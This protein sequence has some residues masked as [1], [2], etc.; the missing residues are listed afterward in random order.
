MPNGTQT[1]SH[2]APAIQT[3]HTGRWSRG[4]CTPSSVAINPT[5]S[6]SVVYSR[7]SENIGAAGGCRHL[8]AQR[9]AAHQIVDVGQVVEDLSRSQHG[10][11]AA[12]DAAEHL[13]EAQI[14]W[15][16]DTNW[17][18]DHDLERVPRPER[19]RELFGLELGPL[20]HV[21]R[22]VRRGLVSWR[23]LDVTVHATRAAVHDAPHAR[24]ERAFE[25]VSGA[26][27][28]DARIRRVA[29]PRLAI[30]RRDVVDD[31][32]ALRCRGHCRGIRQICDA[33][34]RSSLFQPG[35]ARLARRPNEHGHT[36]TRLQ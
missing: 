25:N 36:L 6:L 23:M 29:L 8:P 12:S 15:P 13:Q 9:K 5:S 19:P 28:V 3:G 30:R 2:N 31:V 1:S 33:H 26:V 18:G 22:R 10:K 16:I 14:A 4:G 24:R 32:A 21:A 34:V 17:P 27:H 20:I 11:A 7:P 35:G